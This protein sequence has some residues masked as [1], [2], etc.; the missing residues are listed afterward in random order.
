MFGERALKTPLFGVDHA[1]PDILEMEAVVCRLEFDDR[2]IIILRWQRGMTFGQIG[3]SLGVSR[4]TVRRRLQMAE[5]EVHRLFE[6]GPCQ[7]AP[8]LV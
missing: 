5:S 4:W 2:H 1:P 7:R 8:T 6:S 3:Q